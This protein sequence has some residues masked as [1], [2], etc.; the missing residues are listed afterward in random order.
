MAYLIHDGRP[1]W[2]RTKRAE[3]STHVTLDQ[4]ISAA[5][6]IA[7]SMPIGDRVTVSLVGVTVLF[8]TPTRL[9]PERNPS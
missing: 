9:S 8:S 7:D 6:A 5:K 4:A 3:H 1:Y 2:V